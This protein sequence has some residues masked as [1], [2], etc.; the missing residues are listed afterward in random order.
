MTNALRDLQNLEKDATDSQ[1]VPPGV[2]RAEL[3]RGAQE[4]KLRSMHESSGEEELPAS[5]VA[6]NDPSSDHL[7]IFYFYNLFYKTS[8]KLYLYRYT[9]LMK[10][11]NVD[12]RRSGCSEL[13]F[14]P[15]TPQRAT[16][17]GSFL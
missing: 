4:V 10:D 5:D 9:Y 12:P 6:S 7:Q 1:R 8:S 3:R 14:G 17:P 15:T 2:L 16:A 11:S 13:Q